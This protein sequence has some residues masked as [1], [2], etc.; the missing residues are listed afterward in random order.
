MATIAVRRCVLNRYHEPHTYVIYR[1]EVHCPG[2]T[3]E[4][5]DRELEEQGIT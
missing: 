2:F 3:Q 5:H 4:E 1:Q